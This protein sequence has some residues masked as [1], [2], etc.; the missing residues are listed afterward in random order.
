[1]RIEADSIENVY[2]DVS[3][4]QGVLDP[5]TVEMAF[6]E[7]DEE[8]ADWFP[9]DYA[10]GTAS[11]LVGPGTDVEFAPGTT[12]GVWVRVTQPPETPVK[13]AGRLIVYP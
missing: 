3:L 11:L 8:P 9:A 7:I 13:R 6:P 1:M 10:D 4:T 2:V 12:Y 5:D